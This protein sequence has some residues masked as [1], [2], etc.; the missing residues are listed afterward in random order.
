MGKI[1]PIFG[2]DRGLVRPGASRRAAVLGGNKKLNL[3]Y[4]YNVTRANTVKLRAAIFGAR[5]GT[6]RSR[7][8]WYG[9]STTWG[10]GSFPSNPSTS[11]A[12][13]PLGPRPR[14][15]AL[16][17]ARG[18][19]ANINSFVGC[20]VITANNY[21][22]AGG[23]D[24]RVTTN[25][26]AAE[27][28]GPG[29]AHFQCATAANQ[30]TFTPGNGFTF[31]R[32]EIFM[33][34]P[35]AGNSLEVRANGAT[36]L[37]VGNVGTVDTPRL[38]TAT[39][40]NT[41]A[42]GVRPATAAKVV[43]LGINCYKST[44]NALNFLNFGFPGAVLTD[45][46]TA[47]IYSGIAWA[48]GLALDHVFI[49]M[50][51]NDP[52]QATGQAGVTTEKKKM[53]D[54]FLAVG[55]GVTLVVGGPTAPNPPEATHTALAVQDA[56]RAINYTIANDPAYIANVSILDIN[57]AM[58]GWD[59]AN[60][61]GWMNDVSHPNTTGYQIKAGFIDKWFQQVEQLGP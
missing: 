5:N 9:D 20:G 53:I 46:D 40:A 37:T 11:D 47:T 58:G 52:N 36:A 32:A 59:G 29:G 24:V 43:I 3:P 61:A 28:T 27:A 22:N 45:W 30:L 14:L 55:T 50:D 38:V 60:N 10:T 31:D 17:T 7:I 51:I 56:Y 23:Y 26:W 1:L 18:V 35:A 54:A 44:E 57:M 16:L 19:P 25:A 39:F 2:D 8:G 12:K 4:A 48:A 6:K 41:T 15:A 21:G 42:M 49:E 13:F 33:R 34:D